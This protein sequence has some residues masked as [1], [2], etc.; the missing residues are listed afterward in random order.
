MKLIRAVIRAVK[1]GEVK[2]ALKKTGVKLLKEDAI[3]THGRK[4]GETIFMRGT[5]YVVDFIEKVKLEMAV[6]DQLVG[7]IVEIIGNIAMTE[8]V[9]DCRFHILPLAE[10][11][12][13][14]VINR[15]GFGYEPCNL[16]AG[17]VSSGH[18]VNGTM[19]TVHEGLRQNMKTRFWK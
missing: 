14:Q 3:I 9:G 18:C 6:P 19:S 8:R 13:F 4:K 17:D 5:G 2:A 7:R 15:G 11:R 16:A 12:H 10:T 1:L